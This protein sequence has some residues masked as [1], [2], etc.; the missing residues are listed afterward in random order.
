VFEHERQQASDNIF[1]QLLY[2][3]RVY[4]SET[5]EAYTYLKSIGLKIY[6]LQRDLS[7]FNVEMTDE[8]ILNNRSVLSNHYSSSKLVER[9]RTINSTILGLKI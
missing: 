4:M 3:E 7:L 5:S 9:V 6:S 1:M 8:D 2:G